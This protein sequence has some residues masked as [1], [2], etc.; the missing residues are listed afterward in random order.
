MASKDYG[1][2]FEVKGTG[3]SAGKAQLCDALKVL[4]NRLTQNRQLRKLPLTP[5]QS[6]VLMKLS[7]EFLRT[8]NSGTFEK[9]NISHIGRLVA[10]MKHYGEDLR[11]FLGVNPEDAQLLAALHDLGKSQVA[12]E[13]FNFL[14]T[15]FD[16]EDFVSLRVLPHELYSMY[17]IDQLCRKAGIPVDTAHTLM[18]QIANHNFGPDWHDPENV[19]RL[20]KDHAGNPLRHWWIE[21]WKNWAQAA[22]KHGIE[23]DPKYGCTISPLANTLVLFDRID[24]GDRHSWEKFLNQDLLSGEFDFSAK[25]IIRIIDDSNRTALQQVETVGFQLE[26]LFVDPNAKSS[27]FPPYIDAIEMLQKSDIVLNRVKESNTE[28]LW[29]EFSVDP[30]RAILYHDHTGSWYRLEQPGKNAEATRSLWQ[31][32]QWKETD[33]NAN[34]VSLLLNTIYKDWN[35]RDLKMK[36]LAQ[37]T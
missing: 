5:E 17:W 35:S 3:V 6:E 8:H 23:V 25:N 19:R 26:K 15:V 24:G 11:T 2:L 12:P 31:D 7:L 27:N 21:R 16:A 4:E 18:D 22:V 32:R 29:K 37:S 13:M 34:P 9:D 10:N 28:Y 1:N 14:C 30:K 36:K 33:R 20:A